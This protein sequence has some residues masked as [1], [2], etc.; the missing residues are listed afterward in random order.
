MAYSHKTSSEVGFGVAGVGASGVLVTDLWLN[1][2]NLSA[3]DFFMA[4]VA[5]FAAGLII[6][7][8]TGVYAAYV[9]VTRKKEGPAIR[10]AETLPSQPNLSV[11]DPLTPL[12]SPIAPHDLSGYVVTYDGEIVPRAPTQSGDTESDPATP[13]PPPDFGP[14]RRAYREIMIN[15]DGNGLVWEPVIHSLI[16]R[17]RA[18]IEAWNPRHVARFDDP[19]IADV[20]LSLLDSMSH[21]NEIP[22]L[23]DLR[24]RF[25]RLDRILGL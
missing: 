22:T 12:D 7:G 10:K 21:S 11:L 8:V 20:S 4:F 19:N 14:E 6:L 9:G 5:L 18:K 16:V 2:K 24:Q 23:R 13:N 15:C 1:G 3:N 17:T 25:E